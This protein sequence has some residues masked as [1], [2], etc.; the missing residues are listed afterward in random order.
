MA[1]DAFS[2]EISEYKV[3]AGFVVLFATNEMIDN[4]GGGSRASVAI[5]RLFR[6]ETQKGATVN[7]VLARIYAN[8]HKD[9]KAGK[10]FDTGSG[11]V[12]IQ[13]PGKL[14]KIR[15]ATETTPSS[16]R[17]APIKDLDFSDLD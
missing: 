15:H 14:S 5:G 6:E 2:P 12:G 1:D 16:R 7:Q 4:L 9:Q 11:L 10:A 3:P 8:Y 17:P 13:I